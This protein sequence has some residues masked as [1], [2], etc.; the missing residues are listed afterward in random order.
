MPGPSAQI[1][2]ATNERLVLDTKWVGPDYFNMINQTLIEGDSFN[3]SH[4]KDTSRVLIIN[5]VYAKYLS[6]EGSALGA[7]IIVYQGQEPYTV[8]GI[9]ST[10][11]LPNNTQKPKRAYRTSSISRGDI[12]IQVK[13]NQHFS[14]EKIINALADVG[15]DVIIY[16]YISLNQL[17]EKAFF[18]QY[19]TALT[20][21]VL[22]VLT[23]ALSA[24]GLYGILSYST[25]IRR[26]EIGTRLAI[27]A[28][29]SY[30][31]SLVLKDNAKA[32]LLGI[33][34]SVIVLLGLT[35]GFSEQLN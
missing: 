33:L 9:V 2:V 8:I 19:V 4:L 12:L 16:S 7:K 5:D 27:C 20:S 31:I 18:T 14:R 32:I 21:A 23:L 15:K 3:I 1:I 13:D 25:Q 11:T 35:L 34:T 17:K 30:L 22:A 24:I 10:V 28:K 6:P 29:R 26:F